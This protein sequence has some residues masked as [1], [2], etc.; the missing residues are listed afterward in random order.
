MNEGKELISTF[1][2]NL[3]PPK[4]ILT[5]RQLWK[6]YTTIAIYLLLSQWTISRKT[7]HTTTS[8]ASTD[9]RADFYRIAHLRSLFQCL[10]NQIK[11][12]V[13]TTHRCNVIND[14]IHSLLYMHTNWIYTIRYWIVL[15]DPNCN[16][17]T[18]QLFF[19]SALFR[20]NLCIWVS[21]FKKGLHGT[22]VY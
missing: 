1:T 17:K 9:E 7:E 10:G 16:S 21:V 6:R 8:T 18:H 12:N 19:E 2:T 22:N 5:H 11:Y 15:K 13:H 4:Q 14:G 3:K 20:T